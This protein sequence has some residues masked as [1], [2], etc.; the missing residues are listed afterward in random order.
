MDIVNLP[1]DMTFE[2]KKLLREYKKDGCP[3][4]VRI[5]ADKVSE[6]F[7]LYMGGK[8][9]SEIA[10]I[11]HQKKDIIL[12]VAEKSQ[13]HERRMASYQDTADNL[14]EKTKTSILKSADTVATMVLALN[15]Y[16]NKK[17][18]KYLATND[19]GIIEGLNTRHMTEYRKT[20]ESLEKLIAS[21]TGY[22]K[23]PRPPEDDRPSVNININS[24]AEI[25]EQSEGIDIT[26]IKTGGDMLKTLL[27]IKKEK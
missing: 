19:D 12:Y 18:N 2:E 8:S 4:L 26:Q 25:V 23:I 16:Y 17:L 22:K 24:P 7:N 3:G 14:L 27:K 21:S 15:R 6:W 9:Y 11:S 10:Q 1:E 13:W 20:I 5:N